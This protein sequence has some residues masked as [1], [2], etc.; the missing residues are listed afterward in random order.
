MRQSIT[1]ILLFF[2]AI[3]FAQKEFHV[4]PK[5]GNHIKGS[6]NGDG[7]FNNPWDLQTALSQ[8]SERVNG[9]DIIWL[10]KG[11]YNGRYKSKLKSTNKK[12]ISVSGFGND[13]VTSKLD[14]YL[15]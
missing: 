7:S 1:Y 4:F 3:S 11:I 10:H 12:Y 8:S 14:W 13:L 6:P 5:D 2:V 15:Q 9:G